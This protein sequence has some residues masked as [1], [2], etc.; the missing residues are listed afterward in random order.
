[1]TDLRWGGRGFGGRSGQLD[2]L[3]QTFRP[4]KISGSNFSKKSKTLKGRLPP[5]DGSDRRE[6]LGKHVSDDFANMI[7]QVEK[8]F[9]RTFF[10]KKNKMLKGCLPSEDGSDRRETLGKRVSDDFAKLIFRAETFF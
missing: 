3:S 4:N 2:G 8:Q 7:F 10:L 9:W 1:M 6:T 5:E